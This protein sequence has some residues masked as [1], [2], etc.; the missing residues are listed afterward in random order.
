VAGS[1]L[2]KADGSCALTKRG[3]AK[4]NLL[5]ALAFLLPNFIG[6]VLFTAGPVIVSFVAS[7]TNWDLQGVEPTQ[8]NG[9]ENFVS[10]AHD[11][12]FWL[13]LVN[14]FYFLIGLPISM[15]GSLGLAILV[16]ARIRGQVVYRTLLYLPSVT[17]GVAVMLM[18]KMLYNPDFGPINGTM[19]SIAHR[20]GLASY[21]GPD[22]LQSTHNLLGLNP[23][24]L[25][26][27]PAQWG[28]GAREAILIMGIWG[29][30]GS[31]SMLLY[32]AAL[33]NVPK[34]LQEAAQIDGASPWRVFR[35]V[36]WPQLA[37]TTFFILVMGFIGG[38]QGGF[39]QAK[40]MTG[41]GPA[42]TTTTLAYYI[43]T[44]AFEE[45]R[46][47]YA[48]AVSLVLFLLI[49]AVTAVNWKFGNREVSY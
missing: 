30:V 22:W 38:L 25:G 1:A 2:S 43:Y 18:W 12:R 26:F 48:S 39:E 42:G 24:R 21:K 46:M 7:F 27:L 35:N 49:F 23:E 14:T 28:L 47:G 19:E 11:S 4:R 29:A 20:V 17:S 6:F 8:F 34:E 9:I 31:G 40:I 13:Y 32:L 41:G 37:P 36:T 3:R 45:F 15:A 10:M 33:M 16:S 5:I 44:K